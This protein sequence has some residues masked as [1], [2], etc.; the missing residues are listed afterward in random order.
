M[1]E[2]VNESLE[3]CVGELF[4]STRVIT[5]GHDMLSC[6][7]DASVA[8]DVFSTTKHSPQLLKLDHCCRIVS[9]LQLLLASAHQAYAQTAVETTL[10][11]LTTFGEMIQQTCQRKETSVGVDLNFVER[12]SKCETA[13]RDLKELCLPLQGLVSRSGPSQLVAGRLLD[14]LTAL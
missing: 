14:L 7:A 5:F 10:V 1:I 6:Y 8:M 2:C 13:R 3:S 4:E 12:K 9:C 11:L